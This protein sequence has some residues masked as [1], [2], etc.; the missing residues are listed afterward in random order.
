MH[1][2]CTNRNPIVD[3]LVHLPPLPLFVEYFYPRGMVIPTEHD[4]LWI[5]HALR[6]HDRVHHLYL[7]LP[8]S[9]LHKV[10]LL[11]DEHFPILEV[12]TLETE[13]CIPFTLPKAFVAPNLRRLVVP[14]ISPSRRLRLLTS[15]STASLVA[16]TISNIQT[17]SYFRPRVLIARLSSLPQL[18]DLDIGFSIPIP[19]PSTEREL[20]GE[21]RAPVTISSLTALR[22]KGVSAYLE[23]LVA[24]ITAP[25]LEQLQITLFNQIVFALPHLDHLIN[26]TDRL[27]F[28]EAVVLFDRHAISVT[29]DN[30]PNSRWRPLFLCVMCQPLDWQI[31]CAAQICSGI[32]PTLS[33]VE[34]LRLKPDVLGWE[35]P[36]EFQ[37]GA[38]DSTAWHE[39]LRSFI[40]VK[41]LYIAH[42]LSKEISRAL[43]VD[44]VAL[45]PGFL[46][47]LQYIASGDNLFSSFIDTRR[48]VG[49]PVE[50]VKRYH[51]LK[52]PSALNSL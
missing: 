5:Y 12:L 49:R 4:E 51:N 28:P 24:Q 40:G 11:M 41:E 21:Q 18:E 34:R 44:E 14:G 29:T 25:L 39:L 50:F 23:S 22:F 36:T 33:G 38:I 45:D 9:I 16:L 27:K 10:L 32:I 1:I 2:R 19:G 48:G 46:P 47:N 52:Y 3:T 43:Q 20:L 6:L 26:I 42:R 7:C 13:N 8:P 17:S 35:I 30:F 31:D 37:N 15:P